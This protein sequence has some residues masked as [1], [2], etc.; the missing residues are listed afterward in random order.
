MTI[1]TA[2][3]RGVAVLPAPR[4]A[5]L[6]LA[7]MLAAAPCHAA[8]VFTP[9]VGATE[10]YT[11]NV[12]LQNDANKHGD[13][14]SELH[15]GFTLSGGTSRV[16]VTGQAAEYL[17]LYSRGGVPNTTDHQLLYRLDGQA[18]LVEDF[19]FLDA[20]AAGGPQAVSAFGPQLNNNLYAKGNRTEVRTWRISPYLRHHLGS[21]ADLG[22]RVS[23][24]EVDAGSRSLLGSSSGTTATADLTSGRT[25]NTLGWGLHYTHQVLNSE[26]AGH[27]LSETA[28]GNLSL[29]LGHQFSLTASGGHDKY[30]YDALGGRTSGKNWSAGFI[31]TPSSR[32]RL[33]ASGGRRYFGKT[34][35]LEAS[36]RSRHTVWSLNYSD[37]VTT[38]R[39]Q[40]L[41]PAAIDTAAML[42]K[43]FASSIPD[44]VQRQQ[45]VAT[46][47]AATGLP[48]TMADSVN[49][50]SNR[51]MRQKQLQ[52]AAL[53][54][55]GHSDL[56]ITAY[57]SLRNALSAQQTDSALLGSE[58]ATLN[59]HVRQR[60]IS[61]LGNY[62][63]SPRSALVLNATVSRSRSLTTGLADRNA[64]LRL[65]LTHRFGQKLNG[66]VEVRHV[67][68]GLEAGNGS[69][70]RE[71][72]VS[73]T[74]SMQL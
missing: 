32:T 38:S 45:A 60:G 8:W 53:F 57:N 12:S 56:M 41:L 17:F 71:N 73:A 40:F 5:P 64:V 1:T 66:M 7:A 69:G 42:D 59:D 10:T 21:S 46:Y 54:K 28:L 67:S 3:R 48:P 6:A 29:R 51:Y 68:G 72:A 61:A 14:V 35:A 63:L 50:F 25:W 34:G 55:G 19:L 49:Y 24:D 58:L 47:M 30:D 15:P 44:P 52:A 26:V 39:A 9:A 2:K 27:S 20:A 22:V 74:L 31:W 33:A 11:D 43:L 62:T 18:S 36:H 70:Y 23:R 13:F 4:L 37:M 65:G 16:K